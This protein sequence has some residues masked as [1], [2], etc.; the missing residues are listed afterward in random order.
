ME[1]L[2]EIVSEIRR[3]W[4]NSHTTSESLQSTPNLSSA[5]T[6]STTSISEDATRMLFWLT[7]SRVLL[8][9][10]RCVRLSVCS[11]IGRQW[12]YGNEGE[13]V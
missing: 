6:S 1:Y 13:C 11:E 3:E 2:T 9:V 7:Q 5:T 4:K 8:L 10:N 12:V